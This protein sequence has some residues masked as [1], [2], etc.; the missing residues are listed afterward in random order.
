MNT[1]A[2]KNMVMSH[3]L[4]ASAEHLALTRCNISQKHVI[5]VLHTNEIP[6]TENGDH[7]DGARDEQLERRGHVFERAS[8]ASLIFLRLGALILCFS[9]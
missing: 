4:K 3:S 2:R 7:S 1:A 8:S 6:S 5:S 9:L